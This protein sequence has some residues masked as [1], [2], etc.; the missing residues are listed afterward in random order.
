M[1]EKSTLQK[2]V[3][4]GSGAAVLIL[5][6]VAAVLGLLIAERVRPLRR[7]RESELPH[8][9]RNLAIVAITAVTTSLVEA[10]VLQPVQRLVER[11]RVGLLQWTR[12]SAVQRRVLGFLLL[13]Y[14]LWWWHWMN[15]KLPILWRFHVVH[16][17]DLDLD[18]STAL[19]FHFGEMAL[20]VPYRAAQVLLFG[21]DRETL[22]IWQ[23]TLIVSILFHHSNT[24]LPGAVDAA[25]TRMIVTPRMHGIHHSDWRDETDSNW[26]SILSCWDWLHGTMRL[27]IEQD[28]IRIGVPAWQDPADVTLGSL[29]A[30]PFHEQRND[31]L[32]EEGAPRISREGPGDALTAAPSVR[33]GAADQ[34]TT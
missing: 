9:A 18:A 6:G 1:M 27:D 21:I 13:D 32:D 23:R 2:S 15:H 4:K 11:R 22:Q 19:R 16:H 12:L 29:L 10:K 34:F 31:W 26:S 30:M 24:R 14:T 3:T 8:T 17:V 20:S 28:E 25:L 7:R 33:P 5:T